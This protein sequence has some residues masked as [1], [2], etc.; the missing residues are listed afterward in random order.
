M[1]LLAKC[2]T[3]ILV[4]LCTHAF[5]QIEQ[6]DY[7]RELK[8]VSEQWHSLV[9]PNDIFEETSQSLSDLR[10]FGITEANDTVESPYLLR[11]A[12]ENISSRAVPFNT[13]NASH[14]EMG[15]YFTFE[16]P[17][18]EP[19]DQIDLKFQQQNFDWHIQLE[20]S[21]NQQEWFTVIEDYRIL[22]IKN[23][24]T[25]FQFTKL[26]FPKS[27]YRFF[28]IRIDSE[29]KPELQVA[30]ITQTEVTDGVFSNHHINKQETRE[31]KQ[32][33]QTEI[34]ID[35]PLNVPI[36]YIEIDVVDTIDYYRPVTVRYASDS[37][38]TEKDW[39]YTY[40]TLAS[41]TLNSIEKN[42]FKIRST[43][44]KKLKILIH[45]EDN[46]P[47]TIK[48]IEIKG[49]VHELV[50]RFS[51]TA[52]YFLCYG[53]SRVSKPSYDIQQFEDKIP[54]GLTALNLG[55][56]LLIEKAEIAQTEPLFKNKTWLWGIMLAIILLLGWFSI[57]MIRNS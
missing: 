10:I 49:Y 29:E 4:L 24:I 3:W 56:E 48:E 43:K 2:C 30:S 55:K 42:I 53:N 36:S 47:L 31:N 37:I 46:Q 38:K 27:K 28:R 50:A 22:S 54:S 33:K 13:L 6:Y 35:M 1:N 20:G 51:E 52:T 11:I 32:L 14:N 16:I 9:L 45:N 7:K 21:L 41:G 5:A 17:T 8:G 44:A 19:I 25:D 18:V 26:T 39:K 15:Y 57:K 12:T 23:D 40:K 34:D